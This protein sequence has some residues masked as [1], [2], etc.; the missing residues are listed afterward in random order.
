M[1]LGLDGVELLVGE[2]DQRPGH[3]HQQRLAQPFEDVGGD[4]PGIVT[5][6]APFGHRH[7][8]PS[9]VTLAQR[10]DEL[11]DRRR[12]MIDATRRRHLV[13]DRERVAHRSLPAPGDKVD[14]LGR[15]VEAGVGRHPLQVGGEHVER[16]QPELEVLGATADG[17]EH[18][19]RVGGRQHE[20]HVGRWLLERLEQG[21][22]RVVGQ[23]VDL[24]DDVDLPPAGGPERRLRHELPHGLDAPVRRGIELV[25]VERASLGDPHAGVTGTAGLAIGGIGAVERLGQDARRRRFARAARATEEVGVGDPPLAHGVAQ[26]LADV[27]LTLELGPP[28]GAVSPV[29][30][31][32]RHGRRQYPPLGSARGAGRAPCFRGHCVRPGRHRATPV[33]EHGSGASGLRRPCGGEPGWRRRWRRGCGWD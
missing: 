22:R 19:L 4:L 6:A 23:H 30:R 8:G 12:V 15:D 29:Q 9:R 11:A 7:H 17:G 1:G 32:V 13:E 3:A 10:L 16:Q 21:G 14:H 25:D 31:L 5:G 2:P 27:V 26:R 20:H 28:L 33:R 24:V 18:L